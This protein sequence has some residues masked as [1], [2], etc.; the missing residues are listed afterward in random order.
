MVVAPEFAFFTDM[1]QRIQRKAV[2][3]G[4]VNQKTANDLS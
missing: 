1:P 4:T 2:G 3:I